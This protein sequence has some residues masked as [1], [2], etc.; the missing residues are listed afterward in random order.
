MGE[1]ATVINANTG[2]IDLHDGRI[3]LPGVQRDG[4]DVAEPHNA[5]LIEAGLLY[6]I[7]DTTDETPPAKH[8][9]TK[10]A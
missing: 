1:T 2:P 9:T 6:V 10:E 7:G 5:A 8:R 4:V 3:L